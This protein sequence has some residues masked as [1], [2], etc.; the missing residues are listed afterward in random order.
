MALRR[1]A[2]GTIF[3]RLL[4]VRI[5][6]RKVRKRAPEEGWTRYADARGNAGTYRVSQPG[7]TVYGRAAGSRRQGA[8]LPRGTGDA[9]GRIARRQRWRAFGSHRRMGIA[10]AAWA[11]PAR[12]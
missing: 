10:P 3:L 4:N 7:D 5:T 11:P 8:A 12:Q 6:A 2:S 9:G 1:G